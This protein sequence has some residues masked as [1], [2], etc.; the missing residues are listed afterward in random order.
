MKHSIGLHL[1]KRSKASSIIREHIME[2][3]RFGDVLKTEYLRVN[4]CFFIRRL[5]VDIDAHTMS[6]VPRYQYQWITEDEYN[7]HET[8][9][10]EP[11]GHKGQG[12]LLTHFDDD[13]K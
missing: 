8:D 5:I 10:S 11:A 4:G 1:A 9:S 7:Q 6:L 2:K 3:W 12:I 13:K